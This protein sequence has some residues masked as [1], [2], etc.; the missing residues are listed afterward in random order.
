MINANEIT[1]EHDLTLEEVKS[2]PMFAHFSDDQAQEVIF[3]IK[4]F[5]EIIFK[6]HQKNELS[7]STSLTSND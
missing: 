1:R 6:Y 5:S 3:T 2:M 7:K 4:R